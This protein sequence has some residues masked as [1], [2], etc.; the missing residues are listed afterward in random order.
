LFTGIEGSSSPT[1]Q[2]ALRENERI[3]KTYLG[4]E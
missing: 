1:R 4:E 3:R 2:K